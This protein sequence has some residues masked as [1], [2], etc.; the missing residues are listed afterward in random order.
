MRNA[1][2]LYGGISVLS[3]EIF[4]EMI[5]HKVHINGTADLHEKK[6]VIARCSVD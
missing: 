6:Y 3:F 2:R 5:F 4:A 1:S